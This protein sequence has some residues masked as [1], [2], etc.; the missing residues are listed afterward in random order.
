MIL[1]NNR[2]SNGDD[3][4]VNQSNISNITVNVVDS[5]SKKKRCIT[6]NPQ[7]TP[8]QTPP[9][10][11]TEKDEHLKPRRLQS[12]NVY[13]TSDDKVESV[14]EY[15]DSIPDKIEGVYKHDF[16]ILEAHQTILK[17]FKYQRD[18]EFKKLEQRLSNE[19][20]KI[21]NRQNMIERKASL[22]AINNIKASMNDIINNK[23]LN[24]YLEHIQP[25]IDSYS[26]LGS[27][28]K[29][30][31]FAKIKRDIS[32]SE[33]DDELEDFETQVKRHQLILDFIEIARRYIQIDLIRE[34]KEGNN[35]PA[36]GTKLDQSMSSADDDGISTCPNCGIEKISIIQ[37]RTYHDNAR[38]NNSGNNYEDRANF[39]KVLMRYQGKEPD[40]PNQ[41][42]YQKLEN[43]FIENETPK[44]DVD[45][46]GK[47]RFVTPEF[48]RTQ[49]PLNQD[50]EKEGT[51][52]S[53]MFKALKDIGCSE[54]YDHLNVILNEVWGW[55]LP[56]ISYLEDQ[57][58]E[59]YDVSQ[60][61]YEALPKDRKSSLNSQ[62][63]L[64][65]HLKRLGHPCK[66]KDFRIPSTHDILEF[67]NTIWAKMCEVL[68]WENI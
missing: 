8:K 55:E 40:K 32:D 14:N 65:K 16:N 46:D 34:I 66:S 20:K 31:S 61:V 62:F 50:G 64:Y 29:I 51:S 58:M 25:L 54:Y 35:C 30:V 28:S 18:Y 53:L 21:N 12:F 37:T 2:D 63:R 5:W 68:D 67:H 36:C 43:Y 57:I 38:T 41:E 26:L 59:D 17:K 3:I 10:D 56:D 19:E 39:R 4:R 11:T 42:L 33:S 6:M 13:L 23:S 27:L 49:L 7:P 9:P 45:N 22:R 15:T 48:I 47:R 44:I 52:R 60:R 24:E 1:S